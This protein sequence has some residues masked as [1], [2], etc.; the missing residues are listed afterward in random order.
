MFRYKLQEKDVSKLLNKERQIDRERMAGVV[1]LISLLVIFLSMVG[2]RFLDVKVSNIELVDGDLYSI[3][4]EQGPVNIDKTE[5]LRIEKTYTKASITGI[6]VELDKIYTTKGFIYVSS[7][8]PFYKMSQQIIH[9]V[10]S[11]NKPVWILSDTSSISDATPSQ[12]QNAN[13]K[14]IQPFSYAIGTPANFISRVFT[15]IFLQYLA[16]AFGGIALFILIFPLKIESSSKY[17]SESV[18]QDSEYCTSDE[19]IS[20]VA[21]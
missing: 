5:I 4:T 8:D 10:D 18:Q 12:L 1:I 7:L 2:I 19:H 6:P 13:L 11:G 17:D 20:V 14:L 21:K 9:S 3:I 16:F 15:L